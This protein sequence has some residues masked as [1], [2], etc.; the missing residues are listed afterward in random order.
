M[1]RRGFIADMAA[2][3][4]AG[5]ATAGTPAP[6]DLRK[7]ARNAW[8]FALPLIEMAALRA[9]R[10]PISGE[11]APINAFTHARSLAGPKSRAV[12]SP[13]ADTLYSSAFV[14]T[15]KGP[16]CLE[17]PDC[18]KRYLSVQI[19]DM[20]TNNNFILSPRTPGGAPGEWRLLSPDSEP[21]SSR[22][23]RLTTPHAWVLVR[24]LVDGPSDL[25][26]VHAIQ[27]RLV[28]EGPA[29]PPS[30]NDATRT[31]SWPV[32]FA[33]A[34][35]LLNSDPPQFKNGLDAFMRVR[36]AGSGRDFSRA[37]Y[38]AEAVAAIDAGVAEAAAIARSSR[39]RK[40][41][42]DGWT[43][44][45]PDLGEFGENFIFRAI[46]AIT[47]LG[48]LNPAEAMYMR[49]AG[50]GDGLFEGDG[51]YRL[52]LSGPIPVDAFWSLTM[53]ESIGDGRFFLT[54]N[55]LNRYAIGDRTEGLVHGPDGALDI[56]IGRSDP[57]GARTANWLPAPEKGPFAL[58]L[59]AYLPRPELLSDAYR[60]PAIVQV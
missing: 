39:L 4:V 42:I 46:V 21:R 58:T 22:D 20:Y 49:P 19:M 15:T 41:F 13:N 45:R 30:L 24:I 47:G 32:Y 9:R 16:V 23:L 25:S 5:R 38:T 8:L 59:R 6:A 31:S 7:A 40:G 50:D 43:Y 34:E 3:L 1:N 14:D 26:A 44:P 60:L 52:S 18:G 37:G 48:A 51:L 56:W 35:Q 29:L 36:D 2:S 55:P 27:D 57:G 54:E 33:A 28:L 17:V 10:N 12:T 11:P 53:Y